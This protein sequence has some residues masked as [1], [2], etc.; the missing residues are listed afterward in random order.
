MK[1]TAEHLALDSSASPEMRAQV[2]TVCTEELNLAR[3]TDKEH[4]LLA[5]IPKALDLAL[6]DLV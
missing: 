5:E 6:R 4:L 2:R 1:R 3:L